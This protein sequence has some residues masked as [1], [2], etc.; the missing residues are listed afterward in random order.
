MRPGREV[1]VFVTRNSDAEVLIVHRSPKQ[2]G[3][4]HVVAGGVEPG[5][6]VAEAAERELHEETA[7]VAEVTGGIDV[8]EYVD[9]LTK[10]PADRP[11]SHDPGV[12]EV[13]VTC[14]RVGVP[15]DW[16]PTLDWEH[17]RYR[18]C[19]PVEAFETLRWP[20]T[21]YALRKLLTLR[22][23]NST[24]PRAVSPATDFPELKELLE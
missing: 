5:E 15:Q 4:W 24:L 11:N 2:G 18:W 17:D 7:L 13:A 10:E 16:E 23:G 21:A 9:T 14:F 19:H 1:A 22:P 20:G 3:Y 8:T 6:T 12:A